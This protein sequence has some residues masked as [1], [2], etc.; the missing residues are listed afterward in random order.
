MRWRRRL[1][2][3]IVATAG[4]LVLVVPLANEATAGL[5][6]LQLRE[7]IVAG[8]CAAI[9]WELSKHQVVRLIRCVWRRFD[10]GEGGVHKALDVARCESGLDPDATGGIN[11]G[12]WQFNVRYWPGRYDLLIASH[13]RRSRWGLP[14]TPYDARTATIVAAL[15][16]RRGSWLPWSC[17]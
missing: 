2:S 11:Q 4:A 5:R 12:L 6:D 14:D 8:P 13:D 9:P 16:V 17:A 15:T 3:L 10:P 1:A 7:P